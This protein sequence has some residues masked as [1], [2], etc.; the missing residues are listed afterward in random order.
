MTTSFRIPAMAN[1]KPTP[2]AQRTLTYWKLSRGWNGRGKTV[3][4]EQALKVLRRL[5]FSTNPAH[6]LSLRLRSLRDAIIE[7]KCSKSSQ[8]RNSAQVVN[9]NSRRKQQ[10]QQQQR[11]QRQ[12]Q[13]REMD[14]VCKR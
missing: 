14:N 13:Q 12:R 10:Q 7:G 11:Q 6:K 8:R 4:V 3:S 2:L 1:T 5:T 9:L